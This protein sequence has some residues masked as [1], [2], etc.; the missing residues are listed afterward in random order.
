MKKYKFEFTDIKFF[1]HER[2]CR[3]Y[4]NEPSLGFGQ[5]DISYN[6]YNQLFIDSECMSK[7]F[8]KALLCKLVDDCKDFG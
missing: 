6:K 5:V 1:E 2:G 7:D 3:L 4:W 8:V